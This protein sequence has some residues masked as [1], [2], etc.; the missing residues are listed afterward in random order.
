[1]ELNDKDIE[2]IVEKMN[3]IFVETAKDTFEEN[4]QLK[5]VINQIREYAKECSSREISLD[6]LEI[7]DK[8]KVD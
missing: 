6:I 8:V 4:R 5:E 1:M 3:K 2:Q 7:L